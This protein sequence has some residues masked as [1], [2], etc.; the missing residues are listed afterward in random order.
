MMRPRLAVAAALLLLAAVP[1][2]AG[3]GPNV[4]RFRHVMVVVFE[5][6]ERDAI[7]GNPAAPTFAALGRTYASMTDYEAVTH[8]SL[9][10]YLALV[11]GS[12]Q[13]ITSD[14]TSC[15]V[16]APNLAD[17]LEQA[18]LTWKTYAEGLPAPGFAGASAGPYA[19]KHDP[20]L[21]FKDI[22]DRPGRRARVVPFTRLGP[23]LAANRLPDFALVVPNLCDDMHDCPVSIGDAWL[24]ANIVPLLARPQLADSVVFVVFDEGSTNA[25]GGGRVAALAL[26]PL[27]RPGAQF[28]RRTGHYG[29]LRTIED[30][31]GLPRLGS[32]AQATPITG[33]WR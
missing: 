26:G 9:P 18:G 21:Y 27:V 4:P 20:F 25:G 3:G 15:V 14:C 12:T 11:S 22:A 13:G 6:K 8:P 16:D 33:I 7:V 5:N 24:R 32:A 29:L 30:A 17:Q 1:S 19:K 28:R 31:W 23:D 2:A 10:N